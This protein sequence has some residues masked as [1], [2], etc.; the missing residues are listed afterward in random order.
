MSVASD[1][2]VNLIETQSG[3]EISLTNIESEN[4]KLKSIQ[5]TLVDCKSELQKTP[6]HQHDDAQLDKFGQVLNQLHSTC[7]K[8]NKATDQQKEMINQ[9]DKIASE[10]FGKIL[11]VKHERIKSRG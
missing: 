10:S 5:Q 9:I 6:L 1:I 8:L 11:D 3:T 2:K 7:A 4:W